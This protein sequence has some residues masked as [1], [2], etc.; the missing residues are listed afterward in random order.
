MT[1]GWCREV[2]SL[3]LC[4]RELCTVNRGRKSARLSGEAQG[5]CRAY[6]GFELGRTLA[7][8]VSEAL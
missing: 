2:Q 7:L 4:V 3:H 1:A 8:W 5:S 6:V